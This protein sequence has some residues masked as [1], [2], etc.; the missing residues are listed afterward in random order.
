MKYLKLYE[1]F[2]SKGISKTLGF[3]S[4]QISASEKDKFLKDLREFMEETDYPID[5]LSDKFIKYLPFKKAI[6]LKN[7]KDVTNSKGIWAIKYWFS[8]DKGYLGYTATGNKKFDFQ[9]PNEV[10]KTSSLRNDPNFTER[11]ISYIKNNITE[12]GLISKVRDY[13][14]LET[15]QIII[16]KFD[17]TLG[18]A[19]I[20][21]DR[22]RCYAIQGVASGS[23]PSGSSNWR[24]WTRYGD[25]SWF[26]YEAGDNPTD[27]EKLH[28]WKPS[29]EPLKYEVDVE[30]SEKEEML[31]YLNWNT[32]VEHR[33][34]QVSWQDYDRYSI[35]DY[36][37][38][39][40]A[41]FA[42]VVMYDDL[43]N[44]EEEA[45]YFEPV[46]DIKSWREEAKKGATAL[47]TDE[48]IKRVNYENM[49]NRILQ[50]YGIR[51]DSTEADLLNLQ[52]VFSSFL[53]GEKILYSL[54]SQHPD[55]ENI[56][57]FEKRIKELLKTQFG[58]ESHI[59]GI[60]T[61]FNNCKKESKNYMLRYKG[62]EER[63]SINGNEEVIKL[64]DRLSKL[65]KMINDYILKEPINNLFELRSNVSKLFSIGD[66]TRRSMDSL[67]SRGLKKTLENLR[68]NDS[69]VTDGVTTMN[70]RGEEEIKEDDKFFSDL[71]NYVKKLLN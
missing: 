7:E 55:I 3:L 41:D 70:R 29:D 66:Y 49:M 35:R 62:S 43:I 8:T 46:S 51:L 4:N 64:F 10:E 67:A 47:M 36:K 69:D 15:G 44:P 2:T 33:F 24:D 68:Y 12:T 20:F 45:P 53:C 63:I 22:G 42:L 30:L 58:K 19:T 65:S 23:Y 39:E 5:K 50:I 26:I 48:D 13:S 40:S 61:L 28:F 71:E 32:P 11:E 34:R 17:N 59:Q 27:H 21:N 52:K 1:A 6:L 37:E 60:R 56:S 31:S 54:I 14:K 38:I 57:V 25:L 9:M 18:M 16:G